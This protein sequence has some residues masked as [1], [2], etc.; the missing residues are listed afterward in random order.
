MFRRIWSASNRF[1]GTDRALTTLLALLVT[2]IFIVPV[3][4][5]VGTPGRLLIDGVFTLLIVAGVAAVSR[6]KN[7]L[8]IVAGLGVLGLAIRWL[9][10]ISPSNGLEI[11]TALSAMLSIAALAYVV[12][13][14][15]FRAGPVNMARIQGAIAVYLL[16]GLC[17]GEAYEAIALWAPGSFAHSV[18]AEASAGWVYYSFVTLTTV[19]Y[20]DITPVSAAA[21]SLAVLEAL[22]GQLYPAILLARL[23]ALEVSAQRAE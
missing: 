2:M 8:A 22:T 5:F 6:Q 11:A 4:G 17:W 3:L 15:V 7:A 10:R 19:G 1:W 23:V 18:A 20:G 12:L 9:G 16:L 13:M 14:H 21:R